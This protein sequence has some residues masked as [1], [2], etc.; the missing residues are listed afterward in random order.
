MKNN[1]KKNK[2]AQKSG[3]KLIVNG[4][5]FEDHEEGEVEEE[6]DGENNY[7]NYDS[8]A[9]SEIDFLDEDDNMFGSIFESQ[10]VQETQPEAVP[11]AEEPVVP[12]VMSAPPVAEEP[13]V[14]AVMS[15]PPV[16]EK[17]D[18]PA[19]MS[20]APVLTDEPGTL[21][22]SRK[23][24][25]ASDGILERFD[26][27]GEFNVALSFEDI[28]DVFDYEIQPEVLSQL[29]KFLQTPTQEQLEHE[30]QE[31]YVAR[32]KKMFWQYQNQIVDLH[33]K[34]TFYKTFK[35]FLT[36][37][38][39]REREMVSAEFYKFVTQ[40]ENA[41]REYEFKERFLTRLTSE[42]MRKRADTDVQA[43]FSPS[44]KRTRPSSVTPATSRNHA[45]DFSN[46]FP[47]EEEHADKVHPA[48]T[49]API[50]RDIFGKFDAKFDFS[51]LERCETNLQTLHFSINDLNK[52][53][54]FNNM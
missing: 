16:A 19:V 51:D 34:L 23:N 25:G 50:T 17:P 36:G 7:Y 48:L 38:E 1:N 24:S 21:I 15:A 52:Q 3:K 53:K 20:A 8:G 22:V 12:V 5:V 18:V 32:M 28:I 39:K 54:L 30:T 26:V 42:F 6:E 33:H 41:Q 10:P 4:H 14:P 2:T 47:V 29:M 49:D 27:Y 9:E 11:V 35:T 43:F 13:V 46:S 44:P 31:A 37:F 40:P 45:E